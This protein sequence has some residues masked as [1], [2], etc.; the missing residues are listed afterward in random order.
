MSN[1]PHFFTAAVLTTLLLVLPLSAQAR[2]TAVS[3]QGQTGGLTNPNDL[4]PASRALPLRSVAPDFSLTTAAGQHYRLSSLRGRP[5]L[6]EFIAVWCPH[7]QRESVVINRIHERYGS[8]AQHGLAMLSI[9]AN[10]YGRD[11]DTTGS[12]R[13]A[14]R[15]DI[16]W[17]QRT[18]HTREPILIDPTFAT[19]NRYGAGSY[20][21]I[22]IL[23]G[24]GVVRYASQGEVSYGTLAT[25]VV[26]AGA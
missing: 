1:R 2:G 5:V 11:H 17:F 13:L 10:P 12:T 20:P 26:K 16:A 18:F 19:V 3:R 6:L 21:T 23:D 25:A 14:D 7:C 22:Y 15:R 8:T 9:L 24:K 4:N